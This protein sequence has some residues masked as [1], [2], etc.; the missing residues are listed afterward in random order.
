MEDIRISIFEFRNS[1]LNNNDR[2]PDNTQ[3]NFSKE[4]V[5]KKRSIQALF[6]RLKRLSH[7]E[8]PSTFQE[9][10][11]Q[12]KGVVLRLS[13]RFSECWPSRLGQGV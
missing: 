7:I 3:P 8:T 13:L 11:G 4:D 9:Q 1:N 10:N 12:V 5:Y 2:R 6:E